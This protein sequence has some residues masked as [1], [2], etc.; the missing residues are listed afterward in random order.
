METH[1]APVSVAIST[2]SQYGAK[3]NVSFPDAVLTG[4]VDNVYLRCIPILSE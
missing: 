3:L 2:Q 1:Q 4:K